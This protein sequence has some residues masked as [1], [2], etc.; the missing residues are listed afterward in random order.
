[1]ALYKGYSSLD[2]DRGTRETGIYPSVNVR[3]YNLNPSTVNKTPIS[4]GSNTLALTDVA[5]VERNILNHLFTAKGSRLMMPNFGTNLDKMIFEPLD[6][7]L[8]ADLYS[9]IETVIKFDPRVKLIS[10]ILT[11]DYDVNIV[12]VSITL[13]YLE[14]Q[15]TKSLN[16]NIT[17]N[18]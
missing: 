18:K 1:M 11:P 17:F 8:L 16:L 4:E 13:Q 2:F 14:L 15:V 5:L 10:L 7:I 3:Q 6:P 12:S 9:E